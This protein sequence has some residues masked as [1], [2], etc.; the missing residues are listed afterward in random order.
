MDFYS[1]RNRELGRSGASIHDA[2]AVLA[3]T[4]PHLFE[5]SRHPIEI[6]LAGR[7]TR[8]MTVIDRRSH[9]SGPTEADVVWSADEMAVV[10]LVVEA[11]SAF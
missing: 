11:A 7:H 10:D 5:T 9:G 3:A 2:Y 1:A 6:E 4:H 8:G